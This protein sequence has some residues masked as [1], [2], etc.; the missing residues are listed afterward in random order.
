MNKLGFGILCG[1]SVGLV[2][3]IL[4]NKRMERSNK[5]HEQRFLKMDKER[6]ERMVA[7]RIC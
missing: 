6:E 4:T 5:E 7:S 3:V 2:N 1:L